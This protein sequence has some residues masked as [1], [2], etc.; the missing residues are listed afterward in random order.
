MTY[1]KSVLS[2]KCISGHT[3]LNYI[4]NMS[5]SRTKIYLFGSIKNQI[6]GS[7]LPSKDDVL[8]VYFFNM[9]T[10]GLNLYDGASLVIEQGFLYIFRLWPMK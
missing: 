4:I 9:R 3:D 2:C 7:K 5:A 8:S 1:Y 6:L 10:V